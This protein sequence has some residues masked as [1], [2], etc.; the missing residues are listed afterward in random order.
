MIGKNQTINF[1]NRKISSLR[2]SVTVK[3]R[4]SPQIT[5]AAFNP[6]RVKSFI[7]APIK[8]VVNLMIVSMTEFSRSRHLN[9]LARRNC[10]N[11]SRSILYIHTSISWRMQTRAP[12]NTCLAPLHRLCGVPKKVHHYTFHIAIQPL[13]NSPFITL[14]GVRWADD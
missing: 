10:T 6:Y 4:I 12:N 5:Y 11:Q 9:T 3:I 2:S 7:I 13:T 8:K 1:N 14:Y